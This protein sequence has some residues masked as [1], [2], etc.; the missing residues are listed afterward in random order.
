MKPPVEHPPRDLIVLVADKNMEATLVGL[1]K[2][3]QSLGIAPVTY[4]LFVH[5][6]RDP[7]CLNEADDFL[8]SLAGAYRY[9]LVVFD[10]QGC[11][12]E[13]VP[14]DQLAEE[15]KARLVRK[16]WRERAEVVVL[17]PE[18]EVWAWSDSLHVPRCLGWADRSPSLREWLATTGRWPIAEAKPRRPKEALEAA[19]REVRKPRSSAIYLELART[20]S[21]QG[22]DE[23][24][25]LRLTQALRRWFGA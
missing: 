17:A 8:S 13:G 24:A 15:L 22:H 7:G 16:G 9:A 4:D 19:L 23:P 3:P 2:R 1:L 21:L 5:P 12:R 14:P 18:L 11:G 10:H 25:F 6:H 20:V